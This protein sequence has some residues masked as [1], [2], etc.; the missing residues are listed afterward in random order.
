[1]FVYLAPVASVG[2]TR[3]T[4]VRT[5]FQYRHNCVIKDVVRN[6]PVCEM[7]ILKLRQMISVVPSFLSMLELADLL[8]T[9]NLLSTQKHAE[10]VLQVQKRLLDCCA[11]AGFRKHPSTSEL[12]PP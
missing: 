12:Y 5:C 1:M 3:V 8:R 2:L 10:T 6:V 7:N 9:C 4:L 11:H